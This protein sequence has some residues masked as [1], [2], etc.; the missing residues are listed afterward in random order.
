MAQVT[1]LNDSMSDERITQALRDIAESFRTQLRSPVL[2]TPADA[3]LAYE[4]VTFPSEDGVPLEAWLIPREGSDKLVVVNHP[5]GFSR[6]G[7]P[8]DQEP[9]ASMFAS[10]GNNVDVDFILDYRILHDAGYNILT[11][12]LRNFGQSGA[13]NGGIGTSGNFESRDVI[14]SLDYVRSRP[15]LSRMAIGLFSRCLGC[16]ATM[17]AM[18]RRPDLFEGVRCLVG[19]QPLS[20]SFYL[21]KQLG[22]MGIPA[23]RMAELDTYIR[24]VTGFDLEGLSPLRAAE[25]VTTPTLLYQVHDDALSMP[26][27]VQGIFDALAVQDKDLLWIR[28]TT[29]RWDGYTYFQREP[30]LMLDWFAQHMG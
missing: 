3:G 16:N 13:G 24:L 4:G 22:F 2:S 26:D 30:Q 20:P 19:A 7:L 11:Y 1:P 5:K 23:T 10:S 21:E 8:A 9:W 18:A 28:G 27:D 14:G 29:R 12:D 25:A 6:S 15:E 17:F